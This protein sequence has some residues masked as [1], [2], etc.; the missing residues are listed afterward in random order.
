VEHRCRLT[1]S[2]ARCSSRISAA[3]GI[4]LVPSSHYRHDDNPLPQRHKCTVPHHRKKG[5]DPPEKSGSSHKHNAICN[6]CRLVLVWRC[7]SSCGGARPRTCHVP[8]G[9]GLSLPCYVGG[10]SSEL[11]GV[12]CPQT[13]GSGIVDTSNSTA[14]MATACLPATTT[15]GAARRGARMRPQKPWSQEAMKP[16]VRPWSPWLSEGFALHTGS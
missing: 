12:P 8:V 14:L 10:G 16:S 6:A 13:L 1:R 2:K 7:L 9:M 3:D 11:C 5:P 4:A 15:W